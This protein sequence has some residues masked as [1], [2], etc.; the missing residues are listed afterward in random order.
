MDRSEALV[1]LEGGSVRER[2]EAARTL[3]GS[4]N[5]GDRDV[6]ARAI[7]RETV[8]RIRDVLENA[9]T[10][11]GPAHNDTNNTELATKD[12]AA[13][14]V[15]ETTQA[16]VHEVRKL[17]PSLRLAAER[18]VQDFDR[19]TTREYIDRLDSL[20]DA[21]QRLGRAASTP[22]IADFDLAEL[23]QEIAIT[24]SERIPITIER[25]G[26]APMLVLGDRAL[27]S[28]AI[29][30]GLRNAIEASLEI[31]GEDPP[32]VII[33]WDQTDTEY[34]IVVLD[35]GV[36]LPPGRHRAFEVGRT[37]KP[38]HDGIGLAI[39]K[40]AIDSLNGDIQLRPRQH[41]GTS[42]DVSW[43]R[44]QVSAR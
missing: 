25:Q 24:E 35:Q 29:S 19:S 2:L 33:S 26:L 22:V 9:L 7:H 6:L 17:L 28:L 36:G 23:I 5:S 34:W 39:A 14:T 3:R 31:D 32:N 44:L 30:N 15:Q 20:L 43:P 8:P 11:I 4:A 37:S 1:L 27:V 41:G 16:V 10:A 21:I 40:Q 12:T 42:Y 18:D 13:R 38:K